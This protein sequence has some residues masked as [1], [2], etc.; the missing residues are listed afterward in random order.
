MT[1]ARRSLGNCVVPLNV[2]VKVKAKVHVL[3]VRAR[4]NNYYETREKNG[5]RGIDVKW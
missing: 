5:E 2:Y 1:F 4:N 3:I